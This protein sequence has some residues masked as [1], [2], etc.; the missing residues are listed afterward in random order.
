MECWVCGKSIEG[1][2]DAC[3]HC[4]ALA[5]ES[6]DPPEA[7]RIATKRPVTAKTDA[8]GGVIPYR[9]PPALIGYYLGVFSLIPYPIVTCPMGVVAFLLG[10]AGLAYRARNKAARGS[11]HAL[12][13]I[14]VGGTCAVVWGYWLKTGQFP[15]Q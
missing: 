13:G 9:N 11:L 3:P 8:T 5:Q 15:W 14:V 1:S 2:P 7:N 4:G 6:N 10:C 12:V